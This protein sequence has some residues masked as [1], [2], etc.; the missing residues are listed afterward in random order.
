MP[1]Y[2]AAVDWASVNGASDVY[3]EGG[4]L[5]VGTN[6]LIPVDGRLA[7]KVALR[8]PRGVSLHGSAEPEKPSVIHASDS[9]SALALILVSGTSAAKTEIDHLTLVGTSIPGLAQAEDCPTQGL[10]MSSILDAPDPP[11]SLPTQTVPHS[12][13]GVLVDESLAGL[14]PVDLHH[15]RIA[16]VATGIQYGWET[17]DDPENP[18]CET[19]PCTTLSFVPATGACQAGEYAL[20]LRLPSDTAALAYCIQLLPVADCTPT[21]CTNVAHEFLGN[22]ASRSTVFNNAI[23]DTVSGINLIGGQIDVRHNVVLRAFGGPHGAGLT[24]GGRVPHSRSTSWTENYVYGHATGFLGDGL[25]YVSISDASFKRMTGYDGSSF[26]DPRDVTALQRILLDM[27]SADCLSTNPED[28]FVDHVQLQNNRFVAAAGGMGV[29]FRRTNF[30][31]VGFNV[32]GGVD[33]ASASA[34]VLLDDTMNSWVYGN[35]IRNAHHGIA[36]SGAPG[37]RSKSGS[38]WNGVGTNWDEVTKEFSAHPNGF[39][40]TPCTV[41]YGVNYCSESAA[42]EEVC[43]H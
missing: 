33:G 35:T 4:V 34:G 10:T 27:A 39:Q 8:I 2:Q 32:I 9:V 30:A 41:Y 42:S 17:T 28:G 3:L 25:R 5:S 29:A 23:C 24:A 31:W 38:C 26:A 14:G 16:H 20:T 15:L 40:N 36:V 37:K 21:Y 13:Y 7:G 12:A 11:P 22:G 43:E 19:N 1:W 6:N 18:G